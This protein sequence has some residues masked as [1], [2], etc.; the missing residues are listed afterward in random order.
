MNEE[1]RKEIVETLGISNIIVFDIEVFRHNWLFCAETLDG[2]RYKFWDV[3]KNT[4]LAF[5]ANTYAVFVGFN[6]K[7]YDNPIISSIYN[8]LEV[9]EV[10]VISDRIIEDKENPFDIEEC[11]SPRLYWSC[12]LMDDTLLGFSLKGFEA[13]IGMD[14]VE[15][16]VD[17]N[18][19]RPLTQEEKDET[20]KYCFY[21]IEATM[22]LL[23]E[24]RDYLGTKI[25]LAAKS[26]ISYQY[27]LSQTN[28]RLV[29]DYLGAV[30]KPH[31][32]EYDY[33]FP[34]NI[35]YEYVDEGVIEFFKTIKAG[36]L[37]KEES[38]KSYDGRIGDLTYK[39]GVGGIHGCN[40][41]YNNTSDDEYAILNVDVNQFYPSM[42]VEN[43]YLSRNVKDKDRYR[44]CT[45]ERLEAKKNGDTKTANSLK[46]VNNTT[47]GAQ[48]NKY[49]PLYDPKMALSICLSGQL[50][51]LELA[52]HLYEETSC[53]LIQLNTDGIMLRIRRNMIDKLNDIVSEFEDRTHFKFETDD[54]QTIIQRDVNNYLEMQTNGKRKL[55]GGCLVRGISKAG[56]F[57]VNNN[58]NIV[59]L[60]VEKYFFE[61]IP[62]EDTINACN[63][64]FMF[65]IIAK[66]G[67]T[68]KSCY[69]FK[70][71][72]GQAV[73][74][75]IQKCNRVYASFDTSKGTIYKQKKD[76]GTM[77]LVASLPPSVVIDNEA[78]ITIDKVNKSWYIDKAKEIVNDFTQINH[79][80]VE[81][82]TQIKKEADTTMSV[83]QKLVAARVE[84]GNANIQPSGYNAHADF[85]YLELKDIV[86]VANKVFEKYGL[87]F[88]TTFTDGKA[89][90]D[91]VDV[92]TGEK[93]T[94][95]VPHI[96]I[97]DS[98]KFVTN[99][100]QKL[101]AEITYIR[102]YLYM[103][104]LDIVIADEVDA[105]KEDEAPKV[106]SVKAEDNKE[107]VKVKK[108]SATEAKKTP[109]TPTERAEI[110]KDV[111]KADAK[112]D[113]LQ[114]GKL[115]QLVWDIVKANPDKK[116]EF[117]EMMI[118]TNGFTECTKKDADKLIDKFTTMLEK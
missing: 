89:I 24:R 12:D 29:A 38:A 82:M 84:F 62:V 113:E 50:Y 78:K 7:H 76:G 114:I 68:Y 4:L 79:E 116:A 81:I 39:V 47:F 37:Q 103:L 107:S 100:I 18:I 117:T 20:E 69:H 98:A 16:S 80:G 40:G 25:N 115:K 13:H 67:Q 34:D 118:K 19:D 73:Y 15:S 90:G 44:K 111:V 74:E 112:A 14:I 42:I 53:E 8:G 71:I 101:G 9:E 51:L 93:I 99:E 22:R 27:A 102:R 57:K 87:L 48:K 92:V 33:E 49:N 96:R 72:D 36:D 75:P 32:D 17:F 65:Q 6:I 41:V 43:G 10:K 45:I 64:T 66:V 54:I 61:G 11:K 97:G 106:K 59:P 109:A 91:V 26:N 105:Q 1:M 56:A 94:F 104:V 85:E 95:E 110:K 55:K 108:P 46:L 3:N 60:A 58:Y 83:Y 88:M 31:H 52:T 5:L 35:K 21:D 70:L 63:D 28:A 23:Y 77:E 30:K 86:P 2:C